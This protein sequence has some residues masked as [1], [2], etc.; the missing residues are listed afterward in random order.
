MWCE[1]TRLDSRSNFRCPSKIYGALQ[2]E[3]STGA[4]A[5]FTDFAK[6]AHV[7]SRIKIFL[8]GIDQEREQKMKEYID[9]RTRQAADLVVETGLGSGTEAWYLAFWPSPKGS[10]THSLWDRLGNN[11]GL[12]HRAKIH[13]YALKP[14]AFVA[15]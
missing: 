11:P 1:Q 14:A 10:A 7:R 8:A 13:V 5:F 12:D 3:S 4:K 15:V 9:L 6:L 2:C